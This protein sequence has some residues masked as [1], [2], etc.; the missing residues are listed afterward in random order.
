VDLIVTSIPFSTQYEYSPNYADF[1]HTDD[2]D[3]FWAQMGF[4]IPE[5]L[6]VLKPGRDAASTSRTGSCRAG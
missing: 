2:N 5:L 3:H 6:R 1:G 4:L